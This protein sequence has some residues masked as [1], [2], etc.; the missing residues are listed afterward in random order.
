[1][2][3]FKEEQKLEEASKRR[4]DIEKAKSSCYLLM[5]MMNSLNFRCSSNSENDAAKVT[6][7]MTCT[8]LL[9]Y[10]YHLNVEKKDSPQYSL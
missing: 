1:M 3:G 6:F 9:T 10:F 8:A 4:E 7:E 2:C 5:E